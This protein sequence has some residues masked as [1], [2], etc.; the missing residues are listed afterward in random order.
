MNPCGDLGSKT[1]EITDMDKAGAQ[2]L[3][4]LPLNAFRLIDA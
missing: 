4:G 1:L 3:Y 2:K